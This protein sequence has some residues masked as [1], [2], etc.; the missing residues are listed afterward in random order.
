[1]P[2]LVNPP[3]GYLVNCNK[4][5]YSVTPGCPLVPGAYPKHLSTV[6]APG[7]PAHRA[8]ELI[9]AA[10]KLDFAD[11]ERIAMDVKA[12]TLTWALS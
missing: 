8:T 1:M 5:S 10:G 6:L 3:A 2:H 12:L 11:M 4:N 9:E 7:T